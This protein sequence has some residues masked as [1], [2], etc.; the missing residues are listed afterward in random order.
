MSRTNRLALYF[1]LVFLLGVSAYLALEDG[2]TTV[3]KNIAFA[4]LE[5]LR[6]CPSWRNSPYA[7]LELAVFGLLVQWPFTP[8]LEM[9]PN[10]ACMALVGVLSWFKKITIA[11]WLE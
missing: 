10:L 7:F 5:C 3:K 4:S 1:S 2:L 11:A 9:C 6:A 8:P